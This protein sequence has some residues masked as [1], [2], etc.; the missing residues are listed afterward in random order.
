MYRQKNTKMVIS[1]NRYIGFF[2]MVNH[3][4]IFKYMIR[5][6]HAKTKSIIIELLG[7]FFALQ[8]TY[9]PNFINFAPHLKF[10]ENDKE[11]C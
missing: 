5:F 3:L 1:K 2:L 8:P 9:Y 11:I 4:K 7:L 6:N 10:I